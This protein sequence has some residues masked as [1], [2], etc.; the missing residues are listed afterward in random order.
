[1]RLA[2]LADLALLLAAATAAAATA[3]DLAEGD[4]AMVGFHAYQRGDLD[5]AHAA[6]LQ[7]AESRTDCMTNLAS[8]LL[9]MD[10]ENT[11]AAEQLYRRALANSEPADHVH[12]DAAFNL[13]LLLHDRKDDEAAQHEAVQ[14]YGAVIE[15]EPTHWGAWGNLASVAQELRLENALLA[16][17]AYQRAILQL[18]EEHAA[19]EAEV[20]A[21]E[22]TVLSRM[23]Y[24][25]GITLSE[26]SNEQC[27]EFAADS[28]SLLIGV[29]ASGTADG[30]GLVDA[31]V[32]RENGANAMRTA[33]DI[34]PDNAQAVHMLAA[35]TAADGAEGGGQALD[36]ASPAFVKALFDDFSDT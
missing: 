11:A 14:L 21:E 5:E 4:P 10:A 25:L 26:M 28:R 23:Y 16:P 20:P 3:A 13:A 36:K 24:G 9:D 30:G 12:N 22:V 1:M 29:D 17:R 27:A 33:V 32:C 6:Y 15:A 35:M 18:E 2:P 19:S 31:S 7:C 8:V 34:D